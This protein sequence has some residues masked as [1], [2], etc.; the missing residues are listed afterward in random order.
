MSGPFWAPFNLGRLVIRASEVLLS[1]G[2]TE[3]MRRARIVL[4]RIPIQNA[5][6]KWADSQKRAIASARTAIALDQTRLPHRPLVSVVMPVYN[7]PD[8]WLRAAIDS[9]LAQ[10]SPVWELVI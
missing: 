3:V 2:P 9:V 5:Y 4:G 6:S 1:H 10:L 7:T 8:R